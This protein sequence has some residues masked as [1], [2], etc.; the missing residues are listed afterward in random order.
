MSTNVRL[1][2]EI[3]SC[4]ITLVI[5]NNFFQDIIFEVMPNFHIASITLYSQD[6]GLNLSAATTSNISPSTISLSTS[7]S[8]M[9]SNYSGPT[10]S[11]GFTASSNTFS[12][13]GSGGGINISG[14]PSHHNKYQQGLNNRTADLDFIRNIND[15]DHIDNPIGDLNVIAKEDFFT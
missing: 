14:R 15:N 2:L 10:T 1:N 3:K 13:G 8:S 9:Q 11:G 5:T 4:H 12:G 6:N 7:N